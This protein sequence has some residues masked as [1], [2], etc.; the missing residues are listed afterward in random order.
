MFVISFFS[1]L[2]SLFLYRWLSI[3]DCTVR[4]LDIVD[5]LTVF[6]FS[7]LPI[8]QKNQYSRMVI[9]LLK[10]MSTI[11]R[12]AVFA[13][14]RRLKSKSLTSLGKARKGR[15]VRKLFD[16]REKTLQLTNVIKSVLPMF[17]AFLM[18]FEQNTPQV[19]KLHD[20]VVD[21]YRH[22]LACFL[23]PEKLANVRQ[24]DPTAGENQMKSKNV[25]LGSV[26][27]GLLTKTQES[28]D[29]REQVK[30]AYISTAEYMRTKLPLENEALTC[31]SALDP[32]ARGYEATLT[33][34]V[35]LFNLCKLPL[36]DEANM[37]L[38]EYNTMASDSLP[39]LS[40]DCETQLD[41]WWGAVLQK[42]PALAPMIKACL[43]IF[44]G[45]RV[46][47][48]FSMLNSVM[49]NS[50]NRMNAS[51]SEAYQRVKY[52]LL[53]EGKSAVEL[54]SRKNVDY[55]PVDPSLVF[56]IQ[57]AHRRHKS[58]RLLVCKP[59]KKLKPARKI[60]IQQLADAQRQ[61]IL[62]SAKRARDKGSP[63][64]GNPHKRSK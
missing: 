22:F 35:K 33:Q 24:I 43:S 62:D 4:F 11:D 10:G 39:A 42:L 36:S 14:L 21:T 34:L 64:D 48:S 30:S 13:I 8:S 50:G 55:D 58:K 60:T 54:F 32:I 1:P 37:Q 29:F 61:E 18:I 23:K 15:I 46:E 17:K 5:I 40:L 56:H 45:P 28:R 31:L 6:Y 26:T 25:F 41:T 2:S 52:V 47:Q 63:S 20:M 12:A 27:E 57:T 9:G 49:D 3:Y 59:A 16:L 51:T 53:A 38:R 44:T 19:H 7:W